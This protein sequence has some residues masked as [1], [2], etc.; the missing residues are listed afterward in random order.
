MESLSVV[1]ID[2]ASGSFSVF[3]ECAALFPLKSQVGR[4]RACGELTRTCPMSLGW[5][6]FS[7]GSMPAWIVG[8]FHE[9]WGR[10]R[11]RYR[12]LLSALSEF[13]NFDDSFR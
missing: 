2:G 13:R 12:G 11:R 9:S 10:T 8:F 5:E 1:I 4:D 7:Q 6:M 3:C